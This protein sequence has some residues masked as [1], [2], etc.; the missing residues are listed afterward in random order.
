[1]M[2]DMKNYTHLNTAERELIFLSLGQGR[3]YREI[4]QILGRS[5]TTIQ[6]EVERN[7]GKESENA[8]TEYSPQRAAEM[9][10]QRRR[11]SKTT[12]L[13]DLSIRNFVVG[14]LTRGWSPEQIAGRLKLKAPDCFLSY[15]TIYQFI[16]AK[17]N[18][19]LR[20]WEFLRRGHKRR[21]AFGGRKSQ[22]AKRLTIPNKTLID[23]RPAEVNQRMRI[24]D[25]ESDLMEGIRSSQGFVSVTVDRKSG[26]VLLDKLT[27]K[28]ADLRA[29]SIIKTLGKLP[30]INRTLTL[31]NGLENYEHE[32]VSRSLGL[33]TYFCNPYHSW[34]KGTVENTIGLVRNYLPKKTD[35]NPVTQSDLNI[36]TEELNH[37]P[38]KKHGFYTPAEV[39]YNETGWCI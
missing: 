5:H 35:L 11:E 37:R 25:F 33:R 26:F 29:E 7:T 13:D 30:T 6:R 36:I 20:F 3:S 1:M 21:Q 28:E 24:G 9:A 23:E 38:R 2:V 39:V 32:K 10:K 27:T 12:K 15:E 22:S 18:K 19:P 17:E 16:Y 34:E 31:D 4:G 14:K 8:P